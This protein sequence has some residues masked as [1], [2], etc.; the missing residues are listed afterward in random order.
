MKD[1]SPR[2]V[3]VDRHS[4][5][6]RIIDFAQCLFR[7]ELVAMWYGSGWDEDEDW[8]PD[9]EYWERVHQLENPVAI[10]LVVGGRVKRAKGVTLDIRYPD[11]AKIISDV[12][13]RKAG[14][15]GMSPSSVEY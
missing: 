9:V 2:N 1:C 13:C 11:Y 6:P 10:G 12:E 5:T 8:D 7:D 15:V 14:V 3:V 4:Q